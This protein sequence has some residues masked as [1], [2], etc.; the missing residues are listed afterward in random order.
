MFLFKS[1]GVI[2]KRMPEIYS[3]GQYVL[4]LLRDNC[5]MENKWRLYSILSSGC[6][7]I[8]KFLKHARACIMIHTVR[9]GQDKVA[10]LLC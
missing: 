1:K 4:V 9:L 6:S 2:L 8:K 5:N 10:A 3:S 7:K